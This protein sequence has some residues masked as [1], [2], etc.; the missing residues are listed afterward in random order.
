MT[1]WRY[2]SVNL[3]TDSTTVESVPC[4]LGGWAVTADLSAHDCPIKDDTT[5]VYVIPASSTAGTHKDCLPTRF[6][7]SLVIDPNDTATGTVTILYKV[8]ADA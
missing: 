6:E 4:L 5:T 1:E 2:A 3:S 7:T 8:L